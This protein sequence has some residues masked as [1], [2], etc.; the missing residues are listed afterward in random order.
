MS[1][2]VVDTDVASFVFKEH[3]L[4][5]AYVDIL[6]GNRLSISFMTL[7]ELRAGGGERA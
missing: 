5:P 7:A 1:S 6:A 4:A 2:M 3:A